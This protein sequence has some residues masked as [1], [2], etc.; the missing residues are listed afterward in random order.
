MIITLF[1]DVHGNIIALEKLFEIEK[2]KTDLFICHGDVVN[3]APFSNECVQFLDE[4]TNIKRVKGNH[5][6]YFINGFYDGRNEVATSFF[7]NCYKNFD[8]KLIPLLEKYSDSCEI[9]NYTIEHTIFNKYIFADTDITEHIIDKNY[10]IGHSHQ[11]FEREK[12]GFKIFNTGSLGQNRELINVSNYIQLDTDSQKI[13]LKY[14]KHNI[15]FIINQMKIEKYPQLCIDYY[16][17]K[18]QL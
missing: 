9:E 3:Y 15:D 18:K 4:I 5:E 6:N 8:K 14:F 7:E 17:S 13:E 2:A 12:N 10:I 1:G 11:Q 16:L